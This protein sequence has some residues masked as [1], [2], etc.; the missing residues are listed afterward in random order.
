M[1]NV[2]PMQPQKSYLRIHTK[3]NHKGIQILYYKKKNQLNTKE[4]RNARNEEQ[5]SMRHTESNK[6]AK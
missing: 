1:L 3:G 4:D 5:K 6:I 2:L